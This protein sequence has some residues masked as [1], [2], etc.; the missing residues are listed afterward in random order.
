MLVVT[1]ETFLTPMEVGGRNV[2]ICTEYGEI[3]LTVMFNS[4]R[5]KNW[6]VL[7][8]LL[9]YFMFVPSMLD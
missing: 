9:V 4:L 2:Y 3:Y 6:Q 7:S 8:C 1:L 5:Q